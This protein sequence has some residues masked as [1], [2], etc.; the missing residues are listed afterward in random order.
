MVRKPMMLVALG[1][2]LG[3][4]MVYAQEAEEAK[5]VRFEALAKVDDLV[6]TDPSFS[7]D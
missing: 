7:K 2:L 4:Q 3:A 5:L 1:V 6:A